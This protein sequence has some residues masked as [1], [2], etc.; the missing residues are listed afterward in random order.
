[1]AKLTL[2]EVKRRL[3]QINPMITILSSEYK[4]C[5]TKLECFCEIDQT[6]WFAPWN[7][8]RANHGCPQC[9]FNKLANDRKFTLEYVKEKIEEVNPN[10]RILSKEYKNS[11]TKLECECLVDGH[12]WGATFGHLQNGKGCPK[13]WEKKR[14]E[15]SQKRKLT[16]EE[17][18][19]RI[20]EINPMIK[21]LSTEYVDCK[22]HLECECL[23]DGYTWKADFN[24]LQEG[25]GCPKCGGSIKYTL[26]EI[27]NIITDKNPD[28]LV[29][30][31]EYKMVHE[32]LK[33]KCLIDGHEW[34]T[35]PR[36]I[37]RGSGCPVCAIRRV[38]GENSCNWKGGITAIGM[39][40]RNQMTQWRN[41]S[42]KS[43]GFKCV[44][45]KGRFDHIHHIHGFDMILEETF[46]T[47]GIEK[48]E[49]IADY[50]DK[51]LKTLEDICLKIHY[52]YG[53]GACLTKEN[54]ENFHKLYGY[55]NNTPEQWQEFLELK[56]QEKAS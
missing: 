37:M 35:T 24:H 33:Y 52:K 44:I 25:R 41:D 51:E 10:I 7:T 55:G 20:S 21:I 12:I 34:E 19:R 39:Y 15:L 56:R 26:E 5:H 45:S 40:L 4:N 6:V 48:R 23:I 53:L 47:T 54:H 14:I 9:G 31:N 13:C 8:L 28:I 11:M 18:V 30:S 42:K 1:M 3:K 38:S 43:C 32:K 2:E 29:L 16:I 22:S 46:I 17:V 49:K 27:K 36:S 50:S